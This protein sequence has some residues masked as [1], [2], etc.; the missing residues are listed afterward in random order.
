MFELHNQHI[1]HCDL[2]PTNIL[3]TWD[4]HLVLANFGISLTPCDSEEDIPFN[5]CIFFAYG[6]TYVY[7]APELLISHARASFTCAVDIW[8]LGVVI[9]E[10]YTRKVS[11]L[12]QRFSGSTVG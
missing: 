10:M 11:L 6:G 5:Q 1:I 4:G 9:Y 2:E 3:I 8:S 7:Q 12:K